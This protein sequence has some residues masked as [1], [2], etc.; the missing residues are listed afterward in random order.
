MRPR[1]KTTTRVLLD[2]LDLTG[3]IELISRVAEAPVESATPD[4]EVTA[5]I[6]GTE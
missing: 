3:S 6:I 4:E 2:Q 1:T 5:V